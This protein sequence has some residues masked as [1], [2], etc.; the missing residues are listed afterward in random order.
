MPHKKPTTWDRCGVADANQSTGNTTEAE[1]AKG[2][3]RG[4]ARRALPRGWRGAKAPYGVFRKCNRLKRILKPDVKFRSESVFRF[5]LDFFLQGSKKTFQKREGKKHGG[6][7]TV[8]RAHRIK[9]CKPSQTTTED[10]KGQ[11]RRIGLD[12]IQMFGW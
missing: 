12:I 4:E 7:G 6:P 3:A 5:E 1:W 2:S 9:R 10:R 11:Q 8:G